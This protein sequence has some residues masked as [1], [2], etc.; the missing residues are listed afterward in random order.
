[1][2]IS[3]DQEPAFHPAYL[4]LVAQLLT[5]QGIDS[6]PVFAGT[7]LTPADLGGESL[8]PLRACRE[9]LIRSVAATGNPALG[10]DLGATVPVHT[11]GTLAFAALSAGT[12]DSALRTLVRFATLR[13]RAVRL[14][15][16]LEGDAAVLRTH[17]VLPLG[18]TRRVVLDALLVIEWRL[19]EALLGRDVSQVRCT[20]PHPAPPWA[21]QYARVLPHAVAFAGTDLSLHV[22]RTLLARPCPSQDGEAHL[23]AVRECE[24][25]LETTRPGR[26]IAGR[27]RR[28]LLERGPPWP[29]AAAA[30]TLLHMSPRTLFRRLASAGIRY[31]SLLD[32]VRQE[33]AQWWLAHSEAPVE[34][35]ALKLGFED[36]SNFSRSFR[37]WTGHTPRRY[38]ALH[39]PA[40][41]A[42]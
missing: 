15:L 11:H 14:E 34:A 32:E 37:R 24:R 29:D 8:L 22:P 18:E 26:E 17:E 16:T 40:N 6:A 36:P 28:L 25:R 33:Q 7:G 30:A 13:S 10:L 31:Q 21:E 41:T 38:R 23:L 12:V 4:R 27:V 5:G 3:L 19:L 20:L 1:M 2:Q 9:V 42:R 35:I 39:S